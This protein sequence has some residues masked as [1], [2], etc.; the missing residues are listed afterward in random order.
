MARMLV[1]LA[2]A[3]IACCMEVPIMRGWTFTTPEHP[4]CARA[5]V[6]KMGICNPVASDSIRTYASIDMVLSMF[7]S[8]PC[9]P[10][11]TA[12]DLWHPMNSTN[13]TGGAAPT[14]NTV[15]Q[16]NITEG[17]GICCC[18]PMGCPLGES[19]VGGPVT[20]EVMAQAK[21]TA[22]PTFGW[23]NGTAVG[24]S[25]RKLPSQEW[26]QGM[27]LTLMRGMSYMFNLINMPANHPFYIST[28]AMG[29]GRGMYSEGVMNNGATGNSTVSFQVPWS[30]P[31]MLWYQ[32]TFHNYMGWSIT[33]V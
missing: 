22:H 15:C 7:N 4:S 21:T 17:M 24:Y 23:M 5:C 6:S 27:P 31:S 28:D 8:A 14:S 10:A 1:L 9:P 16:A 25:V 33:V 32:C 13:S 20:F 12:A 3:A 30:A 29:M 11:Q 26:V 2:L 19:I 18:D